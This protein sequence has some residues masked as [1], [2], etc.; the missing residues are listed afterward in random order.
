MTKRVCITSGCGKL[1]DAGLSRCPIH[2][3]SR[4]KARGSS[5]ERGYDNAHIKLRASWQR[6]L[7]AGQLVR[8]WRC[9]DPI[10]PGSFDLGHCDDDRTV[11]HGPEHPSC[12]RSTSAHTGRCPHE[13]HRPPPF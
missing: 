3:R 12:N 5:T 4:D 7:D 6:T 10:R 1:I 8:C 11:T 9:G 2:A 13:S